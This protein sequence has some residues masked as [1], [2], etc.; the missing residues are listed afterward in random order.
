MR[1]VN[2]RFSFSVDAGNA[3]YAKKFDLDKNIKRVRGLNLSSD[4]PD[5]LFYRGSQKIELSGEEL[6]PEDW[7]AKLLMSGLSVAPDQK[8]KDLGDAVLAGNGELKIG[9]KDENNPAA[10]FS[11]YKVNINLLCEIG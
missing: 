9:F 8:F 7:E 3:S 2:K 5:Q 1:I 6:F 10:A 4:K 11:A